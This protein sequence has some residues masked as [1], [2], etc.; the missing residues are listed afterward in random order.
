MKK[1]KSM[2]IVICLLGVLS[3]VSIA[4][5]DLNLLG[6]GTSA[7]GTYNLIYDTGLDITWYDYSS[8]ASTWESQVSWADNLSV[9]FGGNVFNDWQLPTTVDGPW[10]W[11]YDG[12]TT[13]GYNIS[14]SKMG[15][16]YYIE[17]GNNGK[18]D[19]SGLRTG[20]STNSPWC[21]TNTGDFENLQPSTYW[22]GTEYA[23]NATDAWSFNF[24]SGSQDLGSMVNNFSGIAI[25]DGLAVVPE[26]VST[27][28]FIVG[29]ATLGLRRFCKKFKE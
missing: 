11:G 10:V 20:C 1:A 23:S 16:L 29:G 3:A 12:T 24:S 21:L 25:R 2:S 13:A 15:H 4:Y 27:T 7:Y 22:S 14:S 17:L 26:P 9:N 28:L 18:H 8:S 5:A 6:Q 19:T